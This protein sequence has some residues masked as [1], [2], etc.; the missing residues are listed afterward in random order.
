MTTAAVDNIKYT[1]INI[2][3][4]AMTPITAIPTSPVDM[5]VS[6]TLKRANDLTTEEIL[7]FLCDVFASKACVAPYGCKS[8]YINTCS[9]ALTAKNELSHLVYGN[10]SCYRYERLQKSLNKKD[11]QD[12]MMPGVCGEVMEVYEL[13]F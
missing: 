12:E 4:E 3:S 10:I 7:M 6:R 1:K 13:L 9:D 11:R 2:E 8:E 5:T